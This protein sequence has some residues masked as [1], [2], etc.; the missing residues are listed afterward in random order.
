[1]KEGALYDY[2]NAAN[3]TIQNG[4]YVPEAN[5]YVRFYGQ[6][7]KANYAFV[8]INRAGTHITTFHIKSVK[9]VRNYVSLGLF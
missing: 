8:G 5:G 3:Y 9:Q 4:T 1:M 7:G 2:L 6:G